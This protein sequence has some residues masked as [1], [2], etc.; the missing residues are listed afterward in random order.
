[1]ILALMRHR[2]EAMTEDDK[3]HLLR[4]KQFLFDLKSVVATEDLSSESALNLTQDFWDLKPYWPDRI[5]SKEDFLGYVN[6]L[7]KI[8]DC[9]AKGASVKE[10]EKKL[11]EQF[12]EIYRSCQARRLPVSHPL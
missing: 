10:E 3:K 8:T 4:G 2:R 1:M 6:Q 9:M 11:L 12:L 5:N 7:E